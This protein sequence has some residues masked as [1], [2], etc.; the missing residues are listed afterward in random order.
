MAV[1]T[2]RWVFS[3]RGAPG[4]DLHAPGR[5]GRRDRSH[6]VASRVVPETLL[7]WGDSGQPRCVARGGSG[8]HRDRGAVNGGEVYLRL[9]SAVDVFFADPQEQIRLI[10]RAALDYL[11]VEMTVLT[12]DNVALMGCDWMSS[13][14]VLPKIFDCLASSKLGTKSN[15]T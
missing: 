5:L 9:H 3:S 11:A 1:D 13:S 4:S 15:L 7:V 8:F 2:D 14:T 10:I 6:V 12:M